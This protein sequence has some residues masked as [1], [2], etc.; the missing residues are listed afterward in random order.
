MEQ[1][2]QQRREPM[3]NSKQQQLTV[4]AGFRLH[5]IDENRRR[6]GV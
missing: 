2:R 5:A 1:Q 3:I 6:W 4:P